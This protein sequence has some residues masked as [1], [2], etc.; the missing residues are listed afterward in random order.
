MKVS[1]IEGNEAKPD[2]YGVTIETPDKKTHE[3]VVSLD[4]TTIVQ[5]AEDQGKE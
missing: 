3:I 2:H 5:E 4:G 1:R